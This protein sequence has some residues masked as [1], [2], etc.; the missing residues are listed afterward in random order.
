M[1]TRGLNI[2]MFT[3][4]IPDYLHD[5]LYLGLNM[6]GHNV[7]DYPVKPSLHGLPHLSE[8]HSE[9][10]TLHL[11]FVGVYTKPDLLII[12]ILSHDQ[13]RVGTRTW[14]S[15]CKRAYS[16]LQP[17]KVVAL[18]ASDS[19]DFTLP[20]IPFDAVFKRELDTEHDTWHK[21]DMAAMM[22][23]CVLTPFYERDV[24]FS[25]MVAPSN[26]NRIKTAKYLHD[27]SKDS[28]MKACI[29][30]D[31]PTM[32]RQQYLQLLARSRCSISV[33]GM[34]KS[35]YRTYEIPSH[36]VILLSQDIGR[37]YDHDFQD[38]EHCFK[39]KTDEELVKCIEK[40]RSMSNIELEEMSQ[41]AWMH[42]IRHHT[43]I[44]RARQFMEKIYGCPHRPTLKDVT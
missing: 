20:D 34:G 40:V 42:T 23:P 6:L 39:F 21:I 28:K 36:R 19:E 38:G 32:P 35:C 5:M 31:A 16:M 27:Y 7:S 22:E 12:T 9:Q 13:K 43:P 4:E 14:C 44:E 11:P 24:D 3:K 1:A 8:F 15:F 41:R 37:T 29:F 30:C 10:L 17:T 33:M 25:Y 26:P 2:T 18:D